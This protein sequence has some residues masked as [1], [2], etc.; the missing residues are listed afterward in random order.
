MNASTLR[1]YAELIAG[2]S[3]SCRKGE[4]I[5]I[6]GHVAAEPLM[7]AVM[8][9]LLRRGAHPVL[10]PVFE[11]ASRPFLL[12]ASLEQIRYGHAVTS[13]EARYWDATIFIRAP[14]NTRPMTGVPPRLIAEQSKAGRQV[15]DIQ[16]AR[17]A[18]G[19]W[20]WS[21]LLYPTQ[22]LAEEA[23][24]S[25]A[26]FE[27]YVVRTCKLDRPDPAAEWRALSRRQAELVGRLDRTSRI[28]VTGGDT[29]LEFSVKG[30]KWVNS[31]GH[32]NMP[33]GEVFTSPVEGSLEGRIRFTFPGIHAGREIA[34]ISLEFRKGRVVRA[35]AAKG[36]D[37][38]KALLKTDPGAGRA[39]EFAIGTNQGADRFVRNMLFD[40]KMA[41]TVHLALGNSFAEA[42]GRN[43]SSVHW[44]LLKDM[45]KGGKIFADGKLIYQNGVL[46]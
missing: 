18:S 38:L 41:G 43:R 20:R 23:G 7:K 29:D 17:E 39:G 31:D 9:A 6:S 4:R 45:R 14:R 27:R 5:L 34:D 32:R 3:I 12:N 11:D 15:H 24:M 25:L 40:E 19:K 13:L 44:D 22:A 8:V 16:R 26:E 33:S 30:R 35:R 28:R 1:K 21:L 10:R 36:E 46:K 37:L 42:G 2:Y